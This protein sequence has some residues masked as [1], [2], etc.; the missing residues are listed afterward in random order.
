MGECMC[1]RQHLARSGV[2]AC[3]P[4]RAQ[5]LVDGDKIA[6][7]AA[8][9]FSEQLRALGLPITGDPAHPHEDESY[10]AFAPGSAGHVAGPPRADGAVSVGVVQVR[11]R[12]A[13]HGA[14]V[15]A[16]LL[17]SRCATNEHSDSEI[18]ADLPSPDLQTA[19][20]NGASTAFIR[21]T[22]G[23]PVVLTKT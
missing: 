16:P 15:S 1:A 11:L 18:L 3:L 4:P 14:P 12:F 9:F 10:D 19:Y 17:S 8:T 2:H 20:A 23:L 7:L 5:H 22:L 6:T 21:G 13:E